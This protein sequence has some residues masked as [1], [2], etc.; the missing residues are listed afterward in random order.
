MERI[1][2][3]QTLPVHGPAVAVE[4]LDGMHDMPMHA[5]D[6]IELVL[7]EAGSAVHTNQ[8]GGRQ[9]GTGFSAVIRPGEV[10]SWTRTRAFKLWN[11]YIG[12]EVFCGEL[13]WFRATSAGSGLVG[14]SHPGGQVERQLTA[15]ATERAIEWLELI[16]AKASASP[17]NA[18]AR[19]GA[20]CGTL[21]EI[22][23][24]Y[25]PGG[26]DTPTAEEP[27]P[28]VVITAIE[29]LQGQVSHP[30]SMSELAAGCHLSASHLSRVFSAATG[31]APMTYLA[32][33]RA[34]RIAAGLI[35]SDATISD[36][37]RHYGWGDPNYASRR[38]RS[39][40]GISPSTFRRR[41]GQ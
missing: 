36:L 34:E 29:L 17:Q 9:V 38:F 8:R 30:W 19:I 3:Q 24:A 10:H 21:G 13:A 35:T 26:S 15:A 22:A 37:G 7:V 4:L 25:I 31:M 12:P 11:V 41:Y 27:V 5:H 33:L 28:P 18:S 23:A 40:F 20:L 14:P 6:F 16:P 2:R 1:V 39:F 32:R